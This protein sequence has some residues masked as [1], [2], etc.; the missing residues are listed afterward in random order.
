MDEDKAIITD[1]STGCAASARRRRGAGGTGLSHSLDAAA[2]LH[3][4]LRAET[5]HMALWRSCTLGS[6]AIS[7]SAAT[8]FS[9]DTTTAFECGSEMRKPMT[10]ETK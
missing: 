10:R 2:A 4:I 5:W 8:S 6:N 9:F 7:L 3:D 1:C